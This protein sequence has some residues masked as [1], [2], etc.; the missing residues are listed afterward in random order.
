M[1]SLREKEINPILLAPIVVIIGLILLYF[2]YLR[3][4]WAADVALRDFNTPEAQA[5]RDPDQKTMSPQAQKIIQDLKAKSGRP[6][7][8]IATHRSRE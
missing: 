3:P 5:K 8:G 1:D 7:G 4:K 2:L 6:G